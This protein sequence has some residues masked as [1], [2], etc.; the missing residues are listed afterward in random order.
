MRCL[1]CFPPSS[2]PFKNSNEQ[3]ISPFSLL[4]SAPLPEDDLFKEK[5]G[6]EEAQEEGADVEEEEEEEEDEE[7]EGD[8]VT[9]ED[10]SVKS[11]AVK[12]EYDNS[13]EEQ[14]KEQNG[15]QNWSENEKTEVDAKVEKGASK[16][17][18]FFGGFKK[19]NNETEGGE[20]GQEGKENTNREKEDKEGEL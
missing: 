7:K 12:E 1:G 3:T 17:N 19:K 16:L 2:G 14:N 4:R 5:D 8:K 6:E 10:Q 11:L 13:S 18:I 20:K 9:G 15:E